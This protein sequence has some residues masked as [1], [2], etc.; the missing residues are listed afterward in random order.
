MKPIK[1]LIKKARILYPHSRQ[2]RK[3]Y[4]RKTLKQGA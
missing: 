4:V 2:S 1:T 3:D